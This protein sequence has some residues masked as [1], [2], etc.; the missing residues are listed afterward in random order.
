MN[1]RIRSMIRLLVVLVTCWL[2]LVLGTGCAARETNK[3][4]QQSDQAQEAAQRVLAE[5]LAPLI[6]Q[7][8]EEANRQAREAID[9]VLQLLASGRGSLRPALALTAGNEPPPPVDTTV[10]EAVQNPHA[11]TTKAA[12]QTGR[13]QVEVENIGW[14]LS[15]ASIVI[16][17][18]QAIGGS[19]ASQ[20]LTGTGMGGLATAALL[21]WRQTAT[22][23]RALGDSVQF[24]NEAVDIK[25]DDD[26]ARGALVKRHKE[27]QRLHGT[28]GLIKAAGAAVQAP[29]P[30]VPA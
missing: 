27:R 6:A 24:G 25:P 13:A 1:I 29:S 7:L 12:Q 26:K 16:Q 22:L 11:F 8:T 21:L 2:V 15:V 5:K 17:Y 20:L 3:S 10:E 18:G 9:Q 4:L 28:Q 19:L 30:P 14:W 23:R